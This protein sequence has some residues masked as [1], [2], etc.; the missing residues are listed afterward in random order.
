MSQKN[1]LIRG[2]LI[3]T[4]SGLL[5]RVLGFFYRIYLADALGAESLGIYQLVF[6]VYGLCYTLFASG[7]QTALSK[8][9]A[10]HR[11]EEHRHILSKTILLAVSTAG[12]LLLLVTLFAPFIAERLLMEERSA[13][14]LK[15]LAVSFPFCAVTACINGYYYGQ[16]KAFVPAATQFLEQT[17]RIAAVFLIL[18]T[19]S[20]TGAPFTCEMAVLGLL[21]GEI[22][23]MAFNTVSMFVGRDAIRSSKLTVFPDTARRRGSTP[24]ITHKPSVLPVYPELLRISLP[25]TGNRFTINL[26]HSAETILLPTFLKLSGASPSEALSLYGILNGMALPFIFFPSTVTNSLSVMLLPAVADASAKGQQGVLRRTIRAGLRYSILISILCLGIF[27]CYGA[28]MGNLIFHNPTAGSYIQTLS[29]LCPFLYLNT[30]LGSILNGL[31]QAPAVFLQ[32]VIASSIRI[33]FLIFLVPRF[34]MNGYLWGMLAGA[35]CLTLLHTRTLR[36][37]VPGIGLPGK[38]ILQAAAIVSGGLWL[39]R[40]LPAFLPETSLV[41]LALRCVI[42]CALFLPL[43]LGSKL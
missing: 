12:L 7:N 9:I 29:W 22:A 18:R 36:R 8:M 32:N 1:V 14:S 41:M 28:D 43:F 38:L 34:G 37:I 39:S 27:L 40:H 2:T 4:I 19:L 30:T 11:Q 5:T 23:S 21:A 25:I 35:L 10:A 31:D 33:L 17:V 20:K 15:I 13:S 24:N 16:K 42:V 6:P 26:L 3:L